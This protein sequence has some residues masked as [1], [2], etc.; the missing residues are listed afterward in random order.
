MGPPKPSRTRFIPTAV[1]V[2]GERV[3]FI[4]EGPAPGSP[5]APGLDRDHARLRVAE[6]RRRGA[7]GH[8]GVFE[9]ARADRDGARVHADETATPIARRYRHAVNVGHGLVGPAA[10]DRDGPGAVAGYYARLQGQ[11]ILDPVDRKL[12][13]VVALQGLLRGH[14]VAGHQRVLGSDDGDFRDFNGGLLEGEVLGD[15]LT[16]RYAKAGHPDGLVSH[17]NV[18]TSS[19]APDGTLLMK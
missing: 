2:P 5:A 6:L 13:H 12:L 3:G 4:T 18:P 11:H 14:L 10:A 15:R 1:V 7:G 9:S 17:T 8:R 19:Y 16:G